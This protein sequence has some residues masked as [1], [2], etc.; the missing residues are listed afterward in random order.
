MLAFNLDMPHGNEIE[1]AM[2]VAHLQL[3]IDFFFF[4]CDARIFIVTR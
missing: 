1:M 3:R 4:Y 2:P